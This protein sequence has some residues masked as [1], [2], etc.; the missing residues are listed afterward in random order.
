VEDARLLLSM[1]TQI[2]NLDENNDYDVSLPHM[3]WVQVEN[4]VTEELE[5]SKS[6]SQLWALGLSRYPGKP[7]EIHKISRGR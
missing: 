1:Y 7:L 3:M 4:S 2:E 6:Q 5:G